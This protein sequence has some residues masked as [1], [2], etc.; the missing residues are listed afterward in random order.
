M[1]KQSRVSPVDFAYSHHALLNSIQE[2]KQAALGHRGY[3]ECTQEALRRSDNPD[4]PGFLQLQSCTPPHMLTQASGRSYNDSPS[5][6]SGY[7]NRVPTSGQTTYK[8]IERP[9]QELYPPAFKKG[10]D[11]QM[12]NFFRSLSLP[13]DDNWRTGAT[14]NPRSFPFENQFIIDG[15]TPAIIRPLAAPL[16]GRPPVPLASPI[17]RLSPLTAGEHYPSLGSPVMCLSA[18]ASPVVGR[19]TSSTLNVANSQRDMS[20]IIPGQMVS[21]I[22]PLSQITALHG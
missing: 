4:G 7:S 12:S 13:K 22:E 19:M 8:S 20:P 18:P 17:Q 5:T 6:G 15:A 1:L 16:D 10:G 2:W 14:P 9:K 21:D 11:E 3:F